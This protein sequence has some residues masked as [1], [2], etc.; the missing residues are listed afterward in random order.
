MSYQDDDTTE[1]HERRI[2]RCRELTCNARIIFLPTASGSRMPVDADTVEPDDEEFDPTRH[3]SHFA[4][5]AGAGKFRK[6]T[7]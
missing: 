4:V 2:T 1:A 5:C 6:R 3:A 7:P